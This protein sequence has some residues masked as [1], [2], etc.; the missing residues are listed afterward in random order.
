MNQKI[1]EIE[2]I[3]KE[4]LRNRALACYDAV[5][6]DEDMNLIISQLN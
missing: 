6:D 3:N 5:E 1:Y 4:M 2:N